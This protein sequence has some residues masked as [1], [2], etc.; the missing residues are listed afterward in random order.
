MEQ[1]KRKQ[2]S[3]DDFCPSLAIEQ[4]EEI[5]TIASISKMF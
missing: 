4:L 2:D 3:L 5:Q 1:H